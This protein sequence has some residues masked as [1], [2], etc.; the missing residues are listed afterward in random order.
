MKVELT[1]QEQAA[2]AMHEIMK[3]E[4]ARYAERISEQRRIALLSDESLAELVGKANFAKK[5]SP[6]P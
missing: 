5:Q 3:R 6:A 1:K 2:L 4:Q